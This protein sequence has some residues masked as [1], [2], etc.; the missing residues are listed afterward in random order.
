ML[1]YSLR[2]KVDEFAPLEKEVEYIE[3]FITLQKAISTE[4]YVIFNSNLQIRNQFILSRI[5]VAFLEN[6]FL[7]GQINQ[8][9]F[10][11]E[12]NLKVTMHN[13]DFSVK[14]K[15]DNNTTKTDLHENNLKQILK[16]YY[17]C[18]HLFNINCNNGIICNELNIKL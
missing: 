17:K 10:P 1:E 8:K 3:N 15:V 7:H 11:I 18:K 2:T 6:A 9:E 12:V 4:S 5:L 13:L 16:L 14:Y